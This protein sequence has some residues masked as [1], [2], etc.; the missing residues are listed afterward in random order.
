MALVNISTTLP[1]FANVSIRP[2]S[3]VLA[4]EKRLR[5]KPISYVR[6]LTLEQKVQMLGL[7]LDDTTVKPG[8]DKNP[9]AG[10]TIKGFDKL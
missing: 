7:S 2:E 4:L 3:P 1:S 6:P 8:I 9:G 5:G 10:K